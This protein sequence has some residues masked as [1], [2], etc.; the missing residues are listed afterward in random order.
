M[1]EIA[2]GHSP[3]KFIIEIA[4]KNTSNTPK[5]DSVRAIGLAMHPRLLLF[6]LLLFPHLT[7]TSILRVP[8]DYGGLKAA[9]LAAAA[10][11]TVQIS[12]GDFSE[13][14]NCDVQIQVP[15][16]IRGAGR[17]K[18]IIDCEHKARGIMAVDV[19]TTPGSNGLIVIE[20]LAIRNGAPPAQLPPIPSPDERRRSKGEPFRPLF[21]HKST[22][23][24]RVSSRASDGGRRSVEE[25]GSGLVR[26]S[27]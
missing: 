27:R 11:D 26:S 17:D 13:S 23:R 2:I 20:N 12:E 22:G 19:M 8:E 15:I 14:E 1:N 9:V 3:M 24:D 21:Q 10:G 4:I 18:T 6:L 16:T 5:T 7:Y 25:A